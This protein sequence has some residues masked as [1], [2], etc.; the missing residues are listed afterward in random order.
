MYMLMTTCFVERTTVIRVSLDI[1]LI[2][3][4]HEKFPRTVGADDLTPLRQVRTPHN[5]IGWQARG[6]E[7][8]RSPG[9]LKESD[10]LLP[11]L[12]SQLQRRQPQEH[13]SFAGWWILSRVVV[14]RS[15]LTGDP[16]ERQDAIAHQVKRL[17]VMAF[18]NQSG[19]STRLRFRSTFETAAHCR[20]LRSR[21]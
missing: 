7:S 6:R 1:R 13:C 20:L 12:S 2:D 19:F 9:R 11:L 14:L 4:M 21:T 17:S 18:S 8:Q 10:S 3:V 5:R 15:G 16:V